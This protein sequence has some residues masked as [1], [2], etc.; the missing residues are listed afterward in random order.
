MKNKYI[1]L[2]IALG[3]AGYFI[4][5]P[6]TGISGA[7][8]QQAQAFAIFCKRPNLPDF[9]LSL[10]A[11][12][13]Q[14]I[15]LGNTSTGTAGG[16]TGVTGGSTGAVSGGNNGGAAPVATQ[17]YYKKMF[18]TVGP[19]GVAMTPAMP[20]QNPALNDGCTPPCTGRFMACMRRPGGGYCY[21]YN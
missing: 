2:I 13:N 21:K 16:N 18:Y 6:Q 8:T 4:M 20:V 17:D 9:I 5:R 15:T 3:I 14:F 19:D 1:F 11:I 7:D 10:C 12:K